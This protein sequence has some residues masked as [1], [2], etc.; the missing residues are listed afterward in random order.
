MDN[1][2]VEIQANKKKIILHAAIRM[3]VVVICAFGWF[4][5][6]DSTA[7]PNYIGVV[8]F[9]ALLFVYACSPFCHWN[10]TLIYYENK[11]V[12]NKKELT[13]D[14]PTEIKWM[15]K[16]TYIAGTRLLIYKI[17]PKKGLKEFLFDSS[18]EIDI[19]YMDKPKEEFIKYYLKQV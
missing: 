4:V 19:T 13:F 15:R 16:R 6:A 1:K 18:N 17:T 8:I 9:M 2:L 10:D 3:L 14:N 7:N 11:I 5:A 12:L